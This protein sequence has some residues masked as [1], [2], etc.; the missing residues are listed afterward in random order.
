MAQ[1]GQK[2]LPAPT[3]T[4]QLVHT[5]APGRSIA[6]QFLQ[7]MLIIRFLSCLQNIL[8]LGKYLYD[9][10]SAR[11]TQ[12]VPGEF[13]EN[14]NL[15]DFFKGLGTFSDLADGTIRKI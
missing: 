6:P 3:G 4:P 1:L 14:F 8:Y 13:I 15:S 12:T 2:F 10:I 5:L 11:K 7:Y 9:S